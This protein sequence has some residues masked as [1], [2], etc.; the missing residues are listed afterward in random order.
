MLPCV[1]IANDEDEEGS[2]TKYKYVIRVLKVGMTIASIVIP[3]FKTAVVGVRITRYD[4]RCNCH[5]EFNR[6]LYDKLTIVIPKQ[7]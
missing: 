2:M 5:A 7:T 3:S 6:R 4:N 1:Y